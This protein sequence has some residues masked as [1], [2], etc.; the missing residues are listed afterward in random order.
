MQDHPAIVCSSA[1]KA[2]KSGKSLTDEIYKVTHQQLWWA[3]KCATRSGCMFA[4]ALCLMLYHCS[5]CDVICHNGRTKKCTYR[6]RI[7]AH[8][9]GVRI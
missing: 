8:S 1:L 6:Y 2:E 4:A 9:S 3:V 5:A 7:H